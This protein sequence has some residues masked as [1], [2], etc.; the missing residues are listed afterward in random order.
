MEKKISF[1]KTVVS[2]MLIAL[3]SILPSTNLHAQQITAADGTVIVGT[4]VFTMLI[5]NYDRMAPNDYTV[6]V[7]KEPTAKSAKVTEIYFVEGL[8]NAVLL[9]D[10]TA[11]WV[12]VG[13]YKKQGYS[14]SYYLQNHTWYNGGGQTL[15]VADGLV[16]VYV[17]SMADPE[18][19]DQYSNPLCYIQRGTV[20]A[21][22][23]EETDHDYVLKTVHTDLL[24]PKTSPVKKV[25]R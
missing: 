14:N 10:A 23:F 17:E 9:A 24:I 2:A 13:G 6:M 8:S 25:A 12:N 4:R 7:R 15:L 21:D 1:R 19:V 22:V 20:I 3:L 18:D 16:P 11:K 5:P